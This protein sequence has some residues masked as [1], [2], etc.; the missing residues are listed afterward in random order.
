MVLDCLFDLTPSF[1]TFMSMQSSKNICIILLVF[2]LTNPVAFEFKKLL[3]NPLIIK[4]TSA[5]RLY[6]MQNSRNI[7]MSYRFLALRG[8]ACLNFRGSSGL[9]IE[10]YDIV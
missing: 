3:S 1:N 7:F 10:S 8:I 9:R 6:G 5:I 2:S 4:H